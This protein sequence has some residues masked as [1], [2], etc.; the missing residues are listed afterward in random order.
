V[1]SVIRELGRVTLDEALALVTLAARKG[2]LGKL[3]ERL[4]WRSEFEI[5]DQARKEINAYID[6]YHHRPHS[7]LRYRTPAEV[8][9]TWDDGQRLAT[10]AA[11]SVDA[12]GV[13]ARPILMTATPHRGSDKWKPFFELLAHTG[14]RIGEAIALTWA[15]VDFGS[16]GSTCGDVSTAA[17]STPPSQGTAGER[18]H[19]QGLSQALWRL[20]GIAAA[21]APVFATREGT[22]L[23]PSNVAAR[24]L[25]PAAKRAGVPWAGFHTFRHT[26]VRIEHVRGLVGKL[27]GSPAVT[28]ASTYPRSQQR[29]KEQLEAGG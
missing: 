15:D 3:K 17:A 23:D 4:V 5:L 12:D 27:L 8:R 14:L 7:G 2:A 11:W 22:P 29:L 1:E 21:D 28:P 9:Q 20:R 13:H 16:V 10:T 18:F 24:I 19:S 25:K 6:A 26:L